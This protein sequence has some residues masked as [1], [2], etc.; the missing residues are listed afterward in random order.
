MF[1]NTVHNLNTHHIGKTSLKHIEGKNGSSVTKNLVNTRSM[2][3]FPN[4][5]SSSM[6]YV[7][8][9]IGKQKRPFGCHFMRQKSV[10]NFL[11]FKSAFSV[12]SNL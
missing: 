12:S 3:T 9:C 5:N 10:C 4:G 11:V 1:V 6:S 8:T 7:Y 2:P